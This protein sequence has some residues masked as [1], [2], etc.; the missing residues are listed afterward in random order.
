MKPQP[1][2]EGDPV[3]RKPKA[4][5]PGLE[6]RSLPCPCCGEPIYRDNSKCK[7]SGNLTQMPTGFRDSIKASTVPVPRLEQLTLIDPPEGTDQ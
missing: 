5:V 4:P 7:G 2:A 6:W 1:R 3:S